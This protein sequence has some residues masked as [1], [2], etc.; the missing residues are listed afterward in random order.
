M[1][2][3]HTWTQY[4]VEPE[5]QVEIAHSHTVSLDTGLNNIITTDP[6][7][8]G[9]S[10]PSPI[11]VSSDPGILTSLH[12]EE[13]LKGDHVPSK[14]R[15]RSK[16]G[17]LGRNICQ[18]LL[19]G[20][21]SKEGGNNASFKNSCYL[22]AICDYYLAKE[23]SKN[24]HLLDNKGKP[25]SITFVYGHL[26]QAKREEVWQL[27]S[28]KATAHPNWLCIGDFNQIL[29]KDEKFS[30]TQGSIAGANLFQQVIS[31]LHLCDLTATGQRFT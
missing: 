15:I 16:L 7:D 6:T 1:G 29:S 30:F 4:L 20:F 8:F 17:R 19:C 24:P 31:N 21:F 18:K 23:T 5:P 14:K 2:Q 10:P 25:I 11:S 28:L 13:W 12:C 26:D 9:P 3:D 22:N 27:S